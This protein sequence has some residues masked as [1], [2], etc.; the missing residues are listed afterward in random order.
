MSAKR[1]TNTVCRGLFLR[2]VCLRDMPFLEKL[3]DIAVSGRH[4]GD[5]LATIP[6][7]ADAKRPLLSPGAG[8]AHDAALPQNHPT[9]S[10]DNGPL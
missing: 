10:A 3:A 4:V 7:K 5:M 2:V 9:K 8:A 6:A 1:H